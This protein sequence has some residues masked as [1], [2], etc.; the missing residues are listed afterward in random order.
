MSAPR[1]AR[2]KRIYV[3][4][5]AAVDAKAPLVLLEDIPGSVRKLLAARAGEEGRLEKY[6]SKRNLKSSRRKRAQ[7]DL[8][9]VRAEIRRLRRKIWNGT[10]GAP[11]AGTAS[12]IK[13][14]EGQFVK[15]G[16][17][18]VEIAVAP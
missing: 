1:S 13:V 7:S 17:A 15:K 14:R 5:G 18:L 16:D 12:A 6:L 11:A 8:G 10:V 9:E 3:K 4:A 2:V